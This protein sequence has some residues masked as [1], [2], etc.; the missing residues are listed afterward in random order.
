MK[1]RQVTAVILSIAILGVMVSPFSSLFC[2]CEKGGCNGKHLQK[3]AACC[4]QKQAAKQCCS[5]MGG[6]IPPYVFKTLKPIC[7]GCMQ[8]AQATVTAVSS[9]SSRTSAPTLLRIPVFYGSSPECLA[10]V[11][12]IA[13]RE[14]S[15]EG[16]SPLYSSDIALHNC[17]QLI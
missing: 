13:A 6:T 2:C 5:T 1:A 8:H 10:S 11:V 9:H 17:V 3:V 15:S 12:Q 4:A 14:Y 16:G 7:S